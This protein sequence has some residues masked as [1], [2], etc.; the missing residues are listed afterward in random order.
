MYNEEQNCGLDTPVRETEL[1]RELER[2]ARSVSALNEK[3][4][5]LAVR[6]KPV[7]IHETPKEV[8]D[9]KSQSVST[10]LGGA[11]RSSSDGVF[12]AEKLISDLLIRLEV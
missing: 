2:L 4:N 5:T 1:S 3:V 10:D 11:I 12:Y 7:L 9:S 8:T 6:L